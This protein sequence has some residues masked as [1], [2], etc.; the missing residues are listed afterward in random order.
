MSIFK[1]K[2]KQTYK[3]TYLIFNEISKIWDDLSNKNQAELLETLGGKQRGNS[4]GALIQAFQSGQVESA[5][6]DSLAS[7]GSAMKEQERWLTSIEAK[8][9]QLSSTWQ[10]F[11]QTVI[12]SEGAKILLDKLNKAL[13]VLTLMVD[14][15]GTLKTLAGGFFA[16]KLIRGGKPCWLINKS[17]KVCHQGV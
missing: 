10:N 7:D 9:Q 5:Y 3:D 15:V 12:N 6:N 11:S 8:T 13:K 4:V 1:D 16:T 2:D 14:K 17:I